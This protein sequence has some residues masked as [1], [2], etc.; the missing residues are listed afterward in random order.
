MAEGDVTDNDAADATAGGG[1]TQEGGAG[2]QPTSG[3]EA[4]GADPAGFEPSGV[5]DPRAGGGGEGG[6]RLVGLGP[7]QDD[8]AAGLVEQLDHDGGALLG[9]LAGGVDGFPETLAQ[10]PVVVDAGEAEV[11]EGEAA[12]PAH[13]LVGFD[14]AAPHVVEQRPQAGLVHCTIVVVGGWAPPVQ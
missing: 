2:Q 8:R 6:G 4:A 7:G 3:S 11:G 5:G 1:A 10:C 12:E 13:G 9:G 14:R